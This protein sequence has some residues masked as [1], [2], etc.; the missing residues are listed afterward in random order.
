[1]EELIREQPIEEPAMALNG[2]SGDSAVSEDI[3]SQDTLGKFKTPRALLEAYNNLQSEFT[4]KC[5][6]LSK[7]QKDKN[8]EDYKA[9]K[10]KDCEN[11]NLQS[12]TVELNKEDDQNKNIETDNLF[13]EDIQNSNS[14]NKENINTTKSSNDEL[15]EGLQNFLF[16]NKEAKSFI[17]EIKENLNMQNQNPFEQAWANV[18]LKHFKSPTLQDEIVNNY[19]K[20]SESLKENIIKDYLIQLKN[21]MPPVSISSSGERLSEVLPDN[22]STLEE[23]KKLVDKMFS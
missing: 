18:V 7:L 17:D 19:V 12:N 5:Q 22:P 10:N 4:K 14:V 8:E 2:A 21:N 3:G 20:S 23:A 9:N 1:M 6:L 13:N 11:S 16:A 15:E